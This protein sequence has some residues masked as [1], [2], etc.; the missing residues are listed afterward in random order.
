MQDE[1]LEAG[2]QVL[3][4][5]L[6][7]PLALWRYRHSSWVHLGVC[8]VARGEDE[9]NRLKVVSNR[10]VVA[11]YEERVF[12]VPVNTQK[13]AL[14]VLSYLLQVLH[15]L[16]L[17]RQKLRVVSIGALVAW[18]DLFRVSAVFKPH[19]S[20][21]GLHEARVVLEF[22]VVNA[23]ESEGDL[24]SPLVQVN[25]VLWRAVRMVEVGRDGLAF[26]VLQLRTLRQDVDEYD[27]GGDEGE[28]AADAAADLR[29]AL[30]VESWD[31]VAKDIKRF[32]KV[33]D[34]DCR[35]VDS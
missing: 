26:D 10:R 6:R 18:Q 31:R 15:L 34:L 7:A 2:A 8:V 24:E 11:E 30:H 3:E 1:H 27:D 20:D 9:V 12:V 17:N 35:A 32:E 21:D 14:G 4:L 25:R 13:A 33:D 5:L 23:L 16:S 29:L 19:H 22:L 28:E